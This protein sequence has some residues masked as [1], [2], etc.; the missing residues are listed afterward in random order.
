MN[1]I[2]YFNNT[3]KD[4][5]HGNSSYLDHCNKIYNILK[6]LQCSEELCLAGLYHSVYGTENYQVPISS[7]RPKIKELIG[8]YAEHLVTIFCGLSNRTNSI[9]NNS[10]A[11][12]ED[13]KLALLYIEY[14]NLKEQ[15]IRLGQNDDL[16]NACNLLLSEITICQKNKHE[17]H[18]LNNK[19]IHVFD[20]V[21]QEC[22]MEWIHNYCITSNYTPGHKSNGINPDPDSRFVCRLNEEDLNRL[23]ILPTVYN[24]MNTLN[25]KLDIID[26]YINH[27]NLGTNVSK[28]TDTSEQDTYTIL[29]FANKFWEQSWGGNIVFYNEQNSNDI[30]YDFKPGRILI[31]DSRLSHKVMPLTLLSKADR[32]SIAIKCKVNKDV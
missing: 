14:A 6:E 20:N 18:K 19:K 21:L 1:A 8:D 26:A 4:L 5:T 9:L 12:D 30:S 29:I 25:L 16:A 2:D 31:F 3:F 17:T 27:Y 32:Y 22:D 13:I 7:S 11:F 10:F 24:S 23:N 28:H 15:L